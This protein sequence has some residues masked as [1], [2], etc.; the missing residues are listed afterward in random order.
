MHSTLISIQKERSYYLRL[1][2]KLK[3]EEMTLKIL[4]FLTAGLN[5]GNLKG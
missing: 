2:G 3:L 4:Q 1:F 5:D